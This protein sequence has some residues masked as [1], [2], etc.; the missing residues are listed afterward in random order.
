MKVGAFEEAIVSLLCLAG[1]GELEKTFCD[2]EGSP[3]CSQVAVRRAMGHHDMGYT[4]LQDA[5]FGHIGSPKR[6]EVTPLVGAE[7]YS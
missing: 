1:N 6:H 2:G 5:H 7:K 4:N 3:S